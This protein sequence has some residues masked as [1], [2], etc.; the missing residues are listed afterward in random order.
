MDSAQFSSARKKLYDFRVPQTR[1]ISGMRRA[2]THLGESVHEVFGEQR[3]AL[4]LDRCEL[5][6]G[7]RAVPHPFG[8]VA[9]FG[10]ER[11]VSVASWW[12]AV[13]PRP[14][15]AAS[16]NHASTARTAR[17]GLWR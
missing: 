7:R 6:V 15:A 1:R 14:A 4:F 12:Y 17:P 8:R 5:S 2:I 9:D 3:P 11:R 16:L 10:Q 13:F